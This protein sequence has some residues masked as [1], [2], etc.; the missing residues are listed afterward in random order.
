MARPSLLSEEERKGAKEAIWNG[1]RSGEI[2]RIFSLTHSSISAIKAGRIW[3]EVPWPDGSTGP[4]PDD[5]RQAQSVTERQSKALHRAL[6]PIAVD[7]DRDF[8]ADFAHMPGVYEK[9]L[10]NAK[11][12]GFPSVYALHRHNQHELARERQKQHPVVLKKKAKGFVQKPL[13]LPTAEDVTEEEWDAIL[14]D[15]G[16]L[17]LVQKA[18]DQKTRD[19]ICLIFRAVSDDSWRR[20]EQAVVAVER[21]KRTLKGERYGTEAAQDDGVG[22]A[23]NHPNG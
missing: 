14:E 2:C 7:M 20:G 17:K 6:G 12:L 16:D 10:R 13:Q 4:M 8:K 5:R 22:E 3:S 21:L 15:Y 19:A 9:M 23:G 1:M 18:D 11:E